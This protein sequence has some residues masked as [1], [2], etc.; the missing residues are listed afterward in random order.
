MWVWGRPGAGMNV[1]LATAGTKDA[2]TVDVPPAI[3]ANDEHEITADAAP[4]TRRFTTKTPQI[5]CVAARTGP[6][7]GAGDGENRPEKN[8]K[9]VIN[10]CSTR[11]QR[12]MVPQSLSLGS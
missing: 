12:P 6:P 9:A 2:E 3:N 5:T 10:R 1:P 7:T 8:Y 11:Y 4:N